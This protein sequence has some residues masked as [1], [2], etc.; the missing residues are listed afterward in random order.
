MVPSATSYIFFLD[1]EIEFKYYARVIE[2]INTS[3]NFLFNLKNMWTANPNFRSPTKP[4]RAKESSF[5]SPKAEESTNNTRTYGMDENE[6]S[7]TG[8]SVSLCRWFKKIKFK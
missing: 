8:E 5:R 3:A 4:I 1:I 2:Y 7:S 6:E